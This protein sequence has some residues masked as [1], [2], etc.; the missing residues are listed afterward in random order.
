A[1]AIR[2]MKS[3]YCSSLACAVLPLVIFVLSGCA[4]L[5]YIGHTE[6]KID[7]RESYRNFIMLPVPNLEADPAAA[8][9]LGD[10]AISL[11]TLKQL[12]E[13]RGFQYSSFEEADLLV[14]LRAAYIE[15]ES[16]EF[17][18]NALADL[19]NTYPGLK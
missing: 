7:D 12:F 9:V 10:A 19:P 16:V 14:G 1:H 4:S 11:L 15:P 13:E 2:P 8:V 5:P 6:S 3:R 17:T 18:G